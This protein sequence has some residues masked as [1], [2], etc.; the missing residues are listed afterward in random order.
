MFKLRGVIPPM[1]TPFDVEGNLD[2][3]ELEKLVDF[4]KQN[5]DGLYICGSYGS[6]PMMSIE[7]RKKVAE[8]CKKIVGDEITLVVHTGTTNT[9]DTVEL[10]Q[11][12][13]QIGCHA[14]AAVGPYYFHHNSDGVVQFYKEIIE[15][16]DTSFPF[17]VYHNPNFSGYQISLDTIKR[18]R[19]LG[20]N[21]VKDATFDI[22]LHATYMRELGEE[23]FDVALGTESMWLSACALG[24]E[25]Y[26]PGLGNAFPEI[27]KQMWKEGVDG[28]FEACRTTQFKVNKMRDIMYLARSTQLAVYAMTEIRGIT[29]SYPRSPFVP[30]TE[31]EKATIKKELEAIGVL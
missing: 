14:G 24:C 21:G 9:K 31:A 23:G 10:T 17:Y 5:V 19:D 1:I 25:S 28:D 16:I 11:H 3:S 30:A 26:I 22:L 4:L 20:L 29:K 18:L 7:E 8:V 6:G 12:A 15:S 2:V 13:Q 27:C